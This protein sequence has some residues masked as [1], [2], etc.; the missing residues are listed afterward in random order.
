M[1][2]RS[3]MHEVG[4][5][6]SP[7]RVFAILHTP[8]AIRGWWGASRCIVHAIEG[9]TWAAEWGDE[10]DPDY[11]TVARIAVFDPPRRMALDAYRYRARSGPLPFQ[12]DFRTEFTVT[13]AALGCVLRVEQVGFPAGPEADEFYAGCEKGWRA[14]FE[15]IRRFL[16][17]SEDAATIGA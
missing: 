10:D 2:T 8:S 4:L 6:A 9:G 3:H 16:G 17:E 14:T 11:L 7:E 1:T 13:P 12:A 15:S 5:A